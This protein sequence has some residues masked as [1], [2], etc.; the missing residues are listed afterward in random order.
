MSVEDTIQL[1]KQYIKD[2]IAFRERYPMCYIESWTPDEWQEFI[3]EEDTIP[4]W[5]ARRHTDVVRELY[6]GFDPMY[7]TNWETIDHACA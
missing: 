6:G 4:D 3:G 5:T 2:L 7:G 1:R